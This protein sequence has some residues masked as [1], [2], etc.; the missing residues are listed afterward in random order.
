MEDGSYHVHVYNAPK[1]S[2]Y[3][4]KDLDVVEILPQMILLEESCVMIWKN[5][6]I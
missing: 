1:D 4:I 6:K 5:R 3:S 2:W